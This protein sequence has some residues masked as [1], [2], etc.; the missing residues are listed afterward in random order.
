MGRAD[1]ELKR[2]PYTLGYRNYLSGLHF[3]SSIDVDMES[4][5][6]AESGMKLIGI[7]LKP[8]SK[9]ILLP[10]PYEKREN[11][12]KEYFLIR[13]ESVPTVLKEPISALIKLLS[14]ASPKLI[15]LLPRNLFEAHRDQ[16][17]YRILFI[18]FSADC[19]VRPI[20]L[21]ETFDNSRR[22]LFRNLRS[23]KYQTL[24]NQHSPKHKISGYYLSEEGYEI[25][26]FLNH[27]AN[28][29]FKD[30]MRSFKKYLEYLWEAK[31]DSYFK[32][33]NFLGDDAFLSVISYPF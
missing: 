14:V 12:L 33:V 31:G 18:L 22:R 5:A 13:Y 4:V 7:T 30:F 9:L 24:I 16:P 17:K 32:M 29:K 20:Q 19:Y 28:Y 26:N 2:N 6:N 23:L 21:L 15:S 27:L 1:S 25:A 8:I 10:C 3:K 11:Y